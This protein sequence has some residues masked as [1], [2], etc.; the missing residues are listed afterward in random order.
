MQLIGNADE[1][2]QCAGFALVVALSLMAFILLL[3]LSVTTLIKVEN[4]AAAQGLNHLRAR[5]HARLALMLAIGQLQQHAGDDARVSARAEI[6][7]D[8]NYHPAARFWTG[9]WDTR[10]PHAAPQWLISGDS[11]PNRHPAADSIQLIGPGAVGDD[12]SQQVAAPAIELINHQGEVS[13]RIA[14]WTS[15][16]GVKASIGNAPLHTRARPNYTTG[17]AADNLEFLCASAQGLE[18]LFPRY[19]RHTSAQAARLEQLH[20]LNQLRALDEFSPDASALHGEA[21]WHAVAPFSRGV[22]ASTLPNHQGGLLRDLSLFP[23]LLSAGFAN[24]LQLAEANAQQLANAAQHAEPLRLY[25]SLRG[26]GDIGPLQHGEI[27]TPVTPILSNIL[28]AFSIHCDTDTN[29]RLYL[30]MRFFCELWNPF[31]STLRMLDQAGNP[32][33]LELEITGLPT[34]QVRRTAGTSPSHASVDIQGLVGH[35]AQ[36]PQA[37]MRIRLKHDASQAWL[38][39]RAQ[40]WTGVDADQH[41]GQSPYISTTTDSKQWN[42]N[43]RTLGGARGIDTQ[44]DLPGDGTELVLRSAEQNTLRIQLF[45]SN[46]TTQQRT[47]LCNLAGMHYERISTTPRSATNKSAHFGYHIVLRGPHLSR[48]APDAYRGLWLQQH[49]HRNPQPPFYRDWN[50]DFDPVAQTGSAYVPVKDGISVLPIPLPEAI[51]GGNVN[52]SIHFPIFRRLWDRSAPHLYKLWQDT[53][54][55]ELPRQRPLALASLQHLYFHNERPF[56][57]GNSWGAAGANNTLAWFD[58]YYFSGFSRADAPTDYDPTRGLPNPGLISYDCPQPAASLAQWQ[59]CAPDDARAARRP[60]SHL[61]VANR[62]NLNSTSVAAWKAVLG[63]LRTQ[64]WNYLDYPVEQAR[65]DAAPSRAQTSQARFFSRFSHSQTETFKAPQA[66]QTVGAEM[67]APAAFY[68]R[69][70]RHFDTEQIDALARQIVERLKAQAAPFHSLEAFLSPTPEGAASLLEQ[71]IAAVFTE[72]GRQQW[73]HAWETKQVRGD[74]AERIDIDY[75]SP[76]FLTQADLMTAIGPML[77]PRSD[78]FTIRARAICLSPTGDEISSATLEATLQR[79]PT[80][81]DASADSG[82]TARKFK[83]LSTRWLSSSEL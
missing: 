39:G 75:L 61:M 42:R 65:G 9:I 25:S 64:D 38:P 1:S 51:H 22:L 74:Q 81:I 28:M 15:D 70:T 6:L 4:A 41:A 21:L 31:T 35:E 13:T 67:V 46:P 12:S 48:N 58:R 45:A 10:E 68:R 71:A 57:V 23:Q 3:L 17:P 52:G 56:Q 49:D 33:N 59:D 27:A 24:Y 29:H 78:T 83:R 76:G 79:S 72:N 7:G 73:D 50:L 16:Q 44:V 30:R 55:F 5:E 63:S 32:L 60:A 8:G 53:P 82:P 26:L 37:P 47:L 36:D 80:P 2:P 19:D 66:P 62:F 69:G 77:A 11:A 14:W 43:S 34:V 40:H 20:S 54:L 18:E